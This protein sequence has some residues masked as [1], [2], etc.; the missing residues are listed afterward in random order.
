MGS[1]LLHFTS[2]FG[3]FNANY[4]NRTGHKYKVQA[5]QTWPCDLFIIPP[6]AGR[7][8]VKTGRAARAARSI[9]WPPCFPVVRNVLYLLSVIRCMVAEP[10]VGHPLATSGTRTSLGRALRCPA[11]RLLLALRALRA[12]LAVR[13]LL[14]FSPRALRCWWPLL[15]WQWRCC[16]GCSSSYE[17]YKLPGGQHHED[18]RQWRCADMEWRSSLLWSVCH[19]LQVVYAEPQGVREGWRL[20][21]SGNDS[22]E[23]QNPWCGI[24]TLRSTTWTPR[25]WGH[26]LCRGFQCPTA[27]RG[28]SDGA[29]SDGATWEGCLASSFSCEKRNFHR[30]PDFAKGQ[31]GA[32]PENM[33]FLHRPQGHLPDPLGP[34]MRRKLHQNI[35]DHW[36]LTSLE[37]N[38]ED[39]DGWKRQSSL[40][41]RGNTYWLWRRTL[42][43]SSKSEE[44]DR[45]HPSLRRMPT[46]GWANDQRGWHGSKMLIGTMPTI[47]GGWPRL[48][49]RLVERWWGSY[50]NYYDEEI[51]SAEDWSDGQWDWSEESAKDDTS[52]LGSIP[53]NERYQEAYNIAQEANKTLA[54][55][56]QAVAKVRP[57]RGYYDPAGMKGSTRGASP[58]PWTTPPLPAG[59]AQWQRHLC[60]ERPEGHH[61]HWCHRVGLRGDK[62][63]WNA[64]VLWGACVP[65]GLARQ[66]NGSIWEW[67]NTAGH[68]KVGH[69]DQSPEDGELLPSGR[70]GGDDSPTT[71]W[72]RNM[73][74]QRR[75]GLLWGV[76]FA[77]RAMDGSWWTNPLIR[78][79]GRH[80]AIDLA[81]EP[82]T[83]TSLLTTLQRP[84]PDRG[85]GDGPGDED[86]GDGGPPGG[87]RARRSDVEDLVKDL[88]E[89][90]EFT[91]PFEELPTGPT[92]LKMLTW[93]ILN[94]HDLEMLEEPLEEM[95]FS[96]RLV[97]AMCW[98]RLAIDYF[99]KMNFLSV[100]GLTMMGWR[101]PTVIGN[102]HWMAELKRFLAE[103]LDPWCGG[104]GCR[105]MQM[106]PQWTSSETFRDGPLE[107]KDMRVKPLVKHLLTPK[108]M[109][110]IQILHMRILLCRVTLGT[111]KIMEMKEAQVQSGCFQQSS[112]LKQLPHVMNKI[113][114]TTSMATWSNWLKDLRSWRTSSL[115]NGLAMPWKPCGQPREIQP[116]RP[117]DN[118][119]Q[120]RPPPD[121]RGQDEGPRR[122]TVFGNITSASWW[123][124]H[125]RGA[126]QMVYQANEMN[127]K[128]FQGKVMEISWRWAA[129]KGAPRP[130]SGWTIHEQKR[131]WLRQA[132]RGL[133]QR[134]A[135]YIDKEHYRASNPE[136]PY[137]NAD[138]SDKGDKKCLSI[139]KPG[140]IS[141]ESDGCKG[142]SQI[143]TTP[144]AGD[145]R[146][147]NSGVACGDHGDPQRWQCRGRG[148]LAGLWWLCGKGWAPMELTT[149]V[150]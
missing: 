102:R 67:P 33:N 116:V 117:L 135:L 66:A 99:V 129:G 85:G 24:S 3:N 105:H 142:Q 20:Q 2:S 83:L 65:C 19:C 101:W 17:V 148:R 36:K 39:T 56:R 57:G 22:K 110:P 41:P 123:H 45:G 118:M 107:P 48:V 147:L 143:N 122:D 128:I 86:D 46:T 90:L 9:G 34:V 4:E 25:C 68:I 73:G 149:R 94:F 77:H 7:D 104:R 38:F 30:A 53:E 42:R 1:P 132:R 26:R 78:L 16:P 115:P 12:L 37:M 58:L 63:G 111:L 134:G 55:A 126:V 121:I 145:P 75:G 95:T 79:R 93:K 97:M 80:V 71:W 92:P 27:F 119:P 61:R 108:T 10:L 50:N 138:D 141:S 72:T 14:G 144:Q 51:Y 54:E 69:Q 43:G 23:L 32:H 13:L 120:V 70:P 11:A 133:C 35:E 81:K 6:T 8:R 64:G 109:S 21:G 82:Q 114:E 60:H 130:R 124:W 103:F 5:W 44:P 31:T 15:R 146:D 100:L 87:G 131:R 89:I 106:R 127:E 98:W 88:V 150:L 125:K 139:A 28:W 112:E 84:L 52:D 47:W 113:M 140:T 40:R 62:H 91:M 76:Y 137:A 136:E 29:T 18:R 96:L 49:G 59:I 74:S